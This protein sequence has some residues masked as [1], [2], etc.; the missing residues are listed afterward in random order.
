MSCSPEEEAAA[1]KPR[2]QA[3]RRIVCLVAPMMNVLR[4]MI[5]IVSEYCAYGL[6]I[7]SVYRHHHQLASKCMDEVSIKKIGESQVEN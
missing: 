2:R 1:A 5:M 4:Q 3:D 7:L 6:H